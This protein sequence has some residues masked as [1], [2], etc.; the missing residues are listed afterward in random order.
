MLYILKILTIISFLFS[1][2]ALSYLIARTFSFRIK[3]FYSSPRGNPIRGIIYSLGKG[4]L[5]WEKESASKNLIV[6]FAGIFYHSGIFSAFVHLLLKIFEFKIPKILLFIFQILFFLGFFSGIGLFLRRALSSHLRKISIP[7]D[8]SANTLV[9]GFL[10]LSAIETFTLSLSS[11]LYIYSILL[12]F[13]IPF[14]KIR[15]C[16]FFFYSKILSGIFFG[17]RGVFGRSRF[18]ELEQ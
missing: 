12:L 17:R 10:L 5:P 3:V 9:N 2:S 7:D 1:I 8:F 4:M 14:G 16:F 13:Y 15:H 6:Y 18:A 11:L